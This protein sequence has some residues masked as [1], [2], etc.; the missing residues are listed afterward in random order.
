[1]MPKIR[2]IDAVT[3]AAIALLSL[4]VLSLMNGSR[5][6][7]SG[8]GAHAADVQKSSRSEK[9]FAQVLSHARTNYVPPE[10]AETGTLS[11]DGG[12]DSGERPSV[13]AAQ[14]V[15]SANA[16][17]SG[18]VAAPESSAE[19]AL[20]DRINERRDEWRQRN[21]DLEMRERLLENAERKIESRIND[22]RALEEKAEAAAAKRDEAENGSLRSLVTMYEA[23]K[24]KDAARVFDR[25]PH[26][27]LVPVVIQMNP[28]KMAEVLA[29]M[30]PEAAERLT[31][32]L[33]NRAK[34]KSE[35]PAKAAGV[36]PPN[37]LPAIDQ[38][39]LR[40]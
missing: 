32:A 4:K 19:Q 16:P 25:L 20:L 27:V 11:D 13:Q 35:A 26:D 40:R 12:K 22:L 14:N 15:A 8:I 33:A 31:V 18:S 23:M 5:T 24:P 6:S 3:L 38:P 39:A 30:S 2:L 9:P 21:K 34:G 1:M 7:E 10:I 37:E 29:M 36:L 17:A 28:R